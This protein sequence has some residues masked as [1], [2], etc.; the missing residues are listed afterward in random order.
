MVVTA[1][2]RQRLDLLSVW[3]LIIVADQSHNGHVISEFDEGVGAVGGDAV[4]GVQ[5]E[6]DWTEDTALR[7]I[8]VEDD[9]GGWV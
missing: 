9:G 1:P 3:C 5:R 7:N 4:V 6:Q 2:G 8:S